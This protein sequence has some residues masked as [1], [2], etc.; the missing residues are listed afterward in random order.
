MI[1]LIVMGLLLFLLVA[2]ALDFGRCEEVHAKNLAKYQSMGGRPYVPENMVG[3]RHPVIPD[4]D[5]LIV[6]PIQR[7]F[8][9]ILPAPTETYPQTTQ[10]L[11]AQ[12]HTNAQAY[13]LAF[14]SS[15]QVD[16][17]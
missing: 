1:G 11:Q 16:G 8:E 4:S 17:F 13:D 9:V 3:Y 14:G 12:R 2:Q 6:G 5:G 7:A 10:E 15:W